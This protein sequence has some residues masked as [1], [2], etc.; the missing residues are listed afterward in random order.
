MLRLERPVEL[1]D[2]EL[3]H[4]AHHALVALHLLVGVETL[5]QDEVIVALEGMP[6]DA[7]VTV[8]V[9]SNQFLELHG[10][11][12]QILQVEGDV[13]DQTRG[14]LGARAADRREDARTY[15][16]ILTVHRRILCELGLLVQFELREALLHARNLAEQLLVRHGLRLRENRR[17]VVVVS[18]LNA[19]NPPRV[20]VLLVLQEDGVV[21]RSE[22]EVI[23][24]LR[25]LHHKILGTHLHV[26]FRGLHLLHGHHR[27]AA[28]LHR[29]EV[30]HRRSAILVVVQRAHRHLGQK[31]QGAL[32][33]DHAVSHDVKRIVVSHKGANVQPSHILNT[34][35]VADAVGQLLIGAD[36]VAELLDAADHLRVGAAELGFAGLI[37]R[38]HNR[39]V[40]QDDT[41]ADHHSVAVGV[42][43]AVHA[44]GVV[45]DDAAN[46]RAADGSRVGREDATVWLQHAI[47]LRPDDA[48]L[49]ADA[50]AVFADL[51]LLPMLAGDDE[52]G[53][54]H[55]LPGE[56]RASG[57]EG[58]GQAV[59][60]AGL[61][62]A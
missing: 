28:L 55:A 39:T 12:G 24:H 25:T 14:A 50:V 40:G 33:S 44:R 7:S 3:S 48:R 10:G 22:R 35:L 4:V 6:V 29:E 36:A 45:A 58:E 5:V 31:G 59:L 9:V 61:N 2:D 37:A 52:D 57:A 62:D 8:A 56:R 51:I 49:Q 54:A 13:F 30:D 41:R 43:T 11:H 19:L 46:H 21:H 34:V 16:P 18:R 17:Q 60:A 27:A 23:E 15:G 1:L 42:H 47:H 38:V 53:V 32:R 20:D 26:L